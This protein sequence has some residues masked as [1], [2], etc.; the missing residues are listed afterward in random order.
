MVVVFMRETIS[1]IYRYIRQTYR[2]YT[3]L[4]WHIH[5]LT[6]NRSLICWLSNAGRLYT[7]DFELKAAP[8]VSGSEP[9]Y[10]YRRKGT[11]RQIGHSVVTTSHPTCVSN[12]ESFR[13]I[14]TSK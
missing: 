4:V 3:G 1:Y 13:S 14:S 10:S 2:R 8:A 9:I 11:D 7:K 6:I 5:S 12:G